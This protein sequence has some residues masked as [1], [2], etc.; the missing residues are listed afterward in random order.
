[1][2]SSVWARTFILADDDP[3]GDLEDDQGN[4]DTVAGGVGEERREYRDRHDQDE[5]SRVL[6][7]PPPCRR[8][9]LSVRAIELP[10]AS[11]MEWPDARPVPP[12]PGRGARTTGRGRSKDPA[13]GPARRRRPA[14]RP[15]TAPGTAKPPVPAPTRG[16]AGGFA[17]ACGSPGR[18]A[19]APARQSAG[20]STRPGAG[21]VS[22]RQAP[23]SAR[24]S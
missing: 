1:M 18:R 16:P 12:S 22:S 5:G 4:V 10:R 23:A 9:G 6:H 15:W 7:Q 19:R 13:R 17:R 8:S 2:T 21:G 20:T 3:E 14:S 24:S 11:V